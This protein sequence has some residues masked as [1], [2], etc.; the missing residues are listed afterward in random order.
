MNITALFNTSALTPSLHR[1]SMSTTTSASAHDLPPA[2]SS[3]RY[4]SCSHVPLPRPLVLH[5]LTPP[6]AVLVQPANS[7]DLCT[8]LVMT[9]TR[10]PHTR[11]HPRIRDS[12]ACAASAVAEV[13][14]KTEPPVDSALTAQATTWAQCMRR[15]RRPR[16]KGV[17][18]RST[19]NA[20]LVARESAGRRSGNGTREAVSM[21]RESR[22][23]S[24][25]TSTLTQVLALPIHSRTLDPHTAPIRTRPRIRGRGAY[26]ASRI[27]R[28]FHERAPRR[29]DGGG[30]FP[31]LESCSRRARAT[32]ASITRVPSRVRCVRDPRGISSESACGYAESS[33]GGDAQ[34]N[35]APRSPPTPALSA[36]ELP[37]GDSNSHEHTPPPASGARLHGDSRAARGAGFKFDGEGRK[38]AE[39]NITAF[40]DWPLNREYALADPAGVTAFA[41]AIMSV[42]PAHRL[43]VVGARVYAH[44]DRVDGAAGRFEYTPALDVAREL[45]ALWIVLVVLLAVLDDPG[46]VRGAQALVVRLELRDVD[47]VGPGVILLPLTVA[48]IGESA[49]CHHAGDLD[50]P[51][52]LDTVG[53]STESLASRSRS[54][55][56]PDP[57]STLSIHTITT[58][59]P[60]SESMSSTPECY[61]GL[62]FPPPSCSTPLCDASKSL[63]PVCAP[64]ESPQCVPRTAQRRCHHFLINIYDSR[65]SRYPTAATYVPRCAAPEF[66][67]AFLDFPWTAQHVYES[68][69][70]TSRS[71]VQV[72]T[73]HSATQP[74]LRPTLSFDFWC[75]RHVPDASQ[76][77]A[78]DRR[79]TR[80]ASIKRDAP[81]TNYYSIFGVPATVTA[82]THIWSQNA[83]ALL[84]Q[85][86]RAPSTRQDAPTPPTF[87]C[88]PCLHASASTRPPKPQHLNIGFRVPTSNVPLRFALPHAIN[89][90]PTFK[91]WISRSREV[92]F[93]LPA[94]NALSTPAHVDFGFGLPASAVTTR[95]TRRAAW[96]PREQVRAKL[97]LAPPPS[98]QQRAI[99]MLDLQSPQA[100]VHLALPTAAI[101]PSH[102]ERACQH[103][104]SGFRAPVTEVELTRYHA[105]SRRRSAAFKPWCF[106]V[107][108]N[109]QLAARPLRTT[110]LSGP[111][112]YVP[113]VLHQ[114][115]PTSLQVAV[116]LKA[117]TPTA[118]LCVR[119]KGVQLHLVCTR[120]SV[121][122]FAAAL[123]RERS[124]SRWRIGTAT[125]GEWRANTSALT[126]F[127][128]THSRALDPHAAHSD[129]PAH[130]RS[131]RM[132]GE[133]D[134]AASRSARGFHERGPRRHDDSGLF[135]SL[136]SRSR[137]ARAPAVSIT[138]VG[139]TSLPFHAAP[140]V[141]G[142]PGQ[143]ALWESRKADTTGT[144]DRN[145]ELRPPLLGCGRRFQGRKPDIAYVRSTTGASLTTGP[146]ALAFQ[147]L[148]ACGRYRRHCALLMWGHAGRSWWWVASFPSEA[149]RNG[150]AWARNG[151][152]EERRRAAPPTAESEKEAS[153]DVVHIDCA[154]LCRR[155]P[156]ATSP[157]T[158][159]PLDLDLR[160]IPHAHFLAPIPF[161]VRCPV[162]PL[163]LRRKQLSDYSHVPIPTRPS[164]RAK[165]PQCACA[166][167]SSERACEEQPNPSQ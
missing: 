134:G 42:C 70:D 114:F 23:L 21:P 59:V 53:S 80:R 109:P 45:A 95:S 18:P 73:L 39:G 122:K 125:L 133:W 78:S 75:S 120:C 15:Q 155:H 110:C 106:T 167:L 60:R 144:A 94:L 147:P 25:G 51:H 69:V 33:S 79:S 13:G 148:L 46:D 47:A 74:S 137:R 30:R 57:H 81:R 165:C 19:G 77:V 85:C 124:P 130:S 166:A 132:C 48:R 58:R 98:G 65:E 84:H 140:T 76:T 92:R 6:V 139:P 107:T 145:S 152:T 96:G 103:S 131:L 68:R 104:N 143:S 49:V 108:R 72:C 43:A 37:R 90:P 20:A 67:I 111:L 71:L 4:A 62:E 99:N 36:W 102:H 149:L 135:P 156:C 82:A 113:L 97:V 8:M 118:A 16:R 5:R 160:A 87:N 11:T 138:R 55:A 38:K 50:A 83:S 146:L 9:T 44:P 151:E 17:Q 88:I 141:R 10:M 29:H 154:H 127:S 3:T 115:T 119:R 117:L 105:R 163:V 34:R 31:S 7:R 14:A 66:F 164:Q 63:Q 22:A 64:S 100:T 158:H 56:P 26:A 12:C 116:L 40:K 101:T 153:G 159:P 89:A 123:D 162:V 112:S 86:A 24:P 129:T 128:P 54:S 150:R 61:S 2:P 1:I 136:E 32:A 93:A 28:G 161:I 126:K 27:V 121:H 35:A 91:F 41:L 157:H 142:T 52:R